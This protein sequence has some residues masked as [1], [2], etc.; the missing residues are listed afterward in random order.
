M[1]RII[2]TGATGA[3]GTALIKKAIQRN[4]N[5]LVFTRKDSK[6]NN[7]IVKNKLIQ[8][9]FCSLSEM[10]D[11]KNSDDE[12]YDVFFHL[13]WAGASGV[14]R[15][16][17]NLQEDNIKFAMDAL[18]CAKRFG[19]KKFIGIGSQ[20]EYGL[21]NEPL[22]SS[23]KTNPLTEYGKAKLIAG[24]ELKKRAKDL[25]ID[26]NWVRVLSVYGENDG[27]NTLISYAIKQFTSNNDLEVTKCE[28][29]WDYL[30]SEDAANALLAI[31][32]F[33]IDGKTYVLG[34]GKTKK[35]S[36]YLEI[37]KKETKSKSIIKY[38]S[39]PYSKDQVMYLKA[40]ISELNQDTKW[41]PLIDF[42]DGIK[43]IVIK[44]NKSNIVQ[45]IK[46]GIV[47][48]SNTA[49]SLGIYY[50][51][52][53]LNK[54]LYLIGSIVGF[55]VSV[56]NSYYWNNKYVFKSQGIGSTMKKL[57]KT[58]ISYGSTALLSTL[59]LFIEVEYL[60][61]NEAI[62]PLINMIITIPLNFILNKIWTFKKNC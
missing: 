21:T 9:E 60:S 15:N 62:A 11:M 53:F 42:E 23:T 26:F 32:D 13:A 31:A 45:F 59:L 14:G 35:L 19:C 17:I 22:T 52:I 4:I 12:N 18:E 44:D 5:V 41:K 39:K 57:L 28:Q 3:I 61:V 16:D 50:L 54:D 25:N 29:E 37:I 47:G 27:E 36:D 34:S 33:G 38:G 10:K 58:Y 6:R 51:F 43:K 55:F 2:I 7:N 56:L 24:K 48:A 20:A 8:I 1:N 30:N 49:I 46:F 40:D